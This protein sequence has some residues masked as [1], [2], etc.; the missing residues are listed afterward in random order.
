MRFFAPTLDDAP[1]LAECGAKLFTETFG[2]LYKKADLNA[3]L[4]EVHSTEAVAAEIADPAFEHRVVED[5]GLFIAYCKIGPLGVPA[6]KPKPGALELKQLYVH[7][8]FHGQGIA[9][10]LMQWAMRRAKAR[11]APEMYLSVFQE[12][13]RAQAFYARYG[14]RTVSDYKFMVGKQADAEFIQQLDLEAA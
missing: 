2:P 12:N 11:G 6:P 4:R 5:A 1:A 8:P 7:K 14:F 3:F 10:V 9:P 13:P